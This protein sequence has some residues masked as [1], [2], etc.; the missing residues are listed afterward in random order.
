MEDEEFNV[1]APVKLEPAN[2]AAVVIAPAPL[3]VPPAPAIVKLFTLVNVPSANAFVP[4][5]NNTFVVGVADA[6]V[7]FRVPILLAVP[8][9]VA[10]P[11]VTVC[12]AVVFDVSVNDPAVIEPPVPASIA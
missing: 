9:A 7:T 4:L 10:S 5:F 6:A 2:P 1:S 11:N 12:A 3:P 8:A